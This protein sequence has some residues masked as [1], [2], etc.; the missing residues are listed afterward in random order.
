[1]KNIYSLIL[2]SII[3][4]SCTKD[5]KTDVINPEL[6]TILTACF[7][8]SKDTLTVGESLQLTNCSKDAVIYSYDFGN[9]EISNQES[10]SITFEEGGNFTITLVTYDDQR[11]SKTFSHTVFVETPLESYYHFPDISLGLNGLPIG[12]GIN[13][14]NGNIYYLEKSEDLVGLTIPKF[15]YK[16][17]DN[18]LIPSSVYIAD[19][20]FN[21]GHGFV[22]FQG[23]G[24]KNIHFSRTL[25]ELYGSQEITL[26]NTWLLMST[27]NSATKYLYGYLKE[28]VNSI[29]Y[30]TQKDNGIYKAVIEKRNANG[31]AFDVQFKT[32]GYNNAKLADMIKTGDGYV[33][34][35]GTFDKNITAPN[36]T[37]YSPSLIFFDHDLAATKTVVYAHTVLG[38]HITEVNHLNGAYHIIQ[39]SNGNLA[40]YGNGELTVSKPDGRLIASHYFNID[41]D[42]Q[43]MISLGDTFVISTGDGYLRKYDPNGTEI[44]KLK[45]NGNFIPDLLEINNNLFFVAGYRT[46]DTIIN[47]G[48]LSVVKILYGVVDKDLNLIS[49]ESIFN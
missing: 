2:I 33:A 31:D 46:T 21:T 24:N 35:G 47:L 20:Q 11:H 34:F 10:P 5:A 26:N 43:A 16:E 18:T 19:K 7:T 45:Y 23:N 1:M 37:N 42:I 3:V 49:L 22:N 40:T 12:I 32:I 15:Y 44:G 6:E 39:L 4:V 48:D 9:N 17:L 29:F 8:V 36:I 13:P 14:Q 25:P 28:D 41:N 38:T 27:V 30:G